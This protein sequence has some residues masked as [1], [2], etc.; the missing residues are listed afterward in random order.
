MALPV[1]IA[2]GQHSQVDPL[3]LARND[4][5][6]MLR[7]FGRGLFG[8]DLDAGSLASIGNYGVDIREDEN[9]VYVVADLPG[10]RKEDVDISIEDG[11]LTITAERREEI[12]VPPGGEHGRQGRPSAQGQP[13]QR[14]ER[15]QQEQQQQGAATDQPGQGQ[16]EARG[17][18]LL[19]ER[20]VQRF[21]RSFTLPPNV[22]DQH[23][24]ARL[25]NGVLTITLNKREESKPR[26]V[27]V[28]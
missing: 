3:D 8:D 6:G 24:Q 18:Y 14:E 1:R 9:H 28:S 20:R 23:V 15:S 22:D 19:R 5:N 21:V 2:R 27:Q 12:A 25:E 17:E 10:F 13:G 4:I 7:L 11:T 16:G 26:R